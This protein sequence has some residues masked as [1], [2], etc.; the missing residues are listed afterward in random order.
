MKGKVICKICV[1]MIAITIY[2]NYEGKSNTLAADDYSSYTYGG[3]KNING[4]GD[5][6]RST[7]YYYIDN[8]ALGMEKEIKAAMNDWV[9]TTESKGVTTPICYSRT[10]QKSNSLIDIIVALRTTTKDSPFYKEYKIFDYHFMR[11]LNG[12]WT[13]KG[14]RTGRMF[15]LKAGYSPSNVAW[16]IAD[17]YQNILYVAFNNNL[18][19]R[20]W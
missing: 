16:N 13:Y 8:S 17:Y 11:L 12:Y 4:V 15:E 6:G 9:N 7:K 20:M 3:L 2:L 19:V 1:V 14:G 10:Y 5:Y 18:C